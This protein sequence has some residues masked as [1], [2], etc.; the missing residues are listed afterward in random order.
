MENRELMVLGDTIVLV[1]CRIEKSLLYC[2][3]CRWALWEPF[4]D[5]K[6]AYFESFAIGCERELEHDGKVRS[7]SDSL[8]TSKSVVEK[9]IDGAPAVTGSHPFLFNHKAEPVEFGGEM[10]EPVAVKI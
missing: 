8:E 6:V 5:C 10:L 7:W 2:Q 3:Y 1:I 4:L 9:T